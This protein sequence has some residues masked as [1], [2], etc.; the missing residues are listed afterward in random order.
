MVLKN[1]ILRM[2]KYLLIARRHVVFI[3]SVC[4]LFS[5]NQRLWRKHGFF[6]LCWEWEPPQWLKESAW[7]MLAA[8][9]LNICRGGSTSA[10]VMTGNKEGIVLPAETDG[11][12]T[13]CGSTSVARCFV[14]LSFFSPDCERGNQAS[15]PY[16][17]SSWLSTWA[18]F[19]VLVLARA[20][21]R[22][23][24]NFLTQAKGG[25]H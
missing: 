10:V 14:P 5:K 13:A 6:L 4:Q 8:A 16:L 23:Q 21:P 20:L 22:P 24:W 7:D 18:L 3:Q 19:N 1:H 12:R 2:N 15:Q 17:C 9:G 25:A 11:S